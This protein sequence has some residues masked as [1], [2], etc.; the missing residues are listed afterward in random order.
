MTLLPDRRPTRER[1][2]RPPTRAALALVL[3]L[4]AACRPAPPADDDTAGAET[5]PSE[6]FD[7]QVADGGDGGAVLQPDLPSLDGP[8]TP[9]QSRC[10]GVELDTCAPAGDGWVRTT[11]FPGTACAE[12]ACRPIAMNLVLVFDTSGSMATEVAGATCSGTMTFPACDPVLSCSRMDVSKVVFHKA[13]SQIDPARASMALFRFPSRIDRVQ[14]QSCTEGYQAGALA[15]TAD[16]NVQRVTDKTAWFWAFLQEVLAVPFP[17]SEQEAVAAAKEMARWMDGTES[18]AAAG[19][20]AGGP[21]L[22]CGATM[23][24]P[25]GACCAGTCY[26]HADPELRAAGSTPIGKT[27]FYVGEYLR[28]RVVVD[29]LPCAGDAGCGTRHHR[30]LGGVCV[31]PARHCRETVVVLFTDGGELNDPTSFFAPLPMAKRLAFGLACASDADCSGGAACTGGRCL[32]ENPGQFRCVANGLPCVAGAPAG[33]PLFCPELPGL[34]TYCLPDPVLD[35]TAIAAQANNNVLRAPDGRP[36]AARLVV[37]DAS[38]EN[39]VLGSF[40]LASAGGGRVLTADT[41]DPQA[42]LSVLTKAFDLKNTK[43]CGNVF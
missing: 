29:G 5:E 31:D 40:A 25:G 12:E 3:A 16:S 9:G 41:A 19:T 32:P 21:P 11:C 39:S 33:D 30:C 6:D 15:M 27:L 28:H 35:Q 18:I 17:R 24:C 20:C 43:V 36:F 37:I 34:G 23:D 13:L 26:K 42:F 10:A 1:R 4:F 22:G 38:G 8:C 2:R 14:A 7:T